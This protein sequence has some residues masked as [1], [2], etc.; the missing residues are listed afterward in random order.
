MY[1]SWKKYSIRKCKDYKRKKS[2][3]YSVTKNNA[4]I[5]KFNEK[6]INNIFAGDWTQNTLPCTIEASILSGKKAIESL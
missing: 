5:Q 3:I 4:L 2:H 6:K 1:F